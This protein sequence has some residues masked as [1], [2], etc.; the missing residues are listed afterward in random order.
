MQTFINGYDI[1]HCTLCPRKCGMD[2]TRAAGFCGG[3]SEIRA[4]RRALHHWEEPCTSG[5]GGSG[6]IFFSG[7]SLRCCFC[8][9]A[10]IRTGHFGA[11]L[12]I[13]QLGACMLD[14]QQQG[15][16][17]INF[18]TGSH[19]TPWIVSAVQ[20]IRDKLHIPIV[21][22][23]SGYEDAE[24]LAM[25]DGV[26]DIYLPDFKYFC[27]ETAE[28]YAQARNYPEVAAYALT[29][30]LRQV[31]TPVFDENG[32][33]QRGMIVRH[34]VLPGH[35]HESMALLKA[36]SQLLPKEDFLLS[37]MGQYT[38]PSEA[39]PYKNL[40]RRLTTMEYQSVLHCAQELDFQGFSQELSS[41]QASY[42]PPL[43][44]EGIPH[45][46]KITE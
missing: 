8:Q 22:N 21:W 15:A 4:A 44:L 18:V 30:M 17:N 35:R 36:L 27:A 37:L 42:I 26:V 45:D 19:Y 33:L 3:G 10:V 13:D 28:K 25:L 34:L 43:N 7:C 38:P 20:K 24:T 12:T 11:P 41:A 40:N 6:T 9:N 46:T 23:S 31:G 32:I 2:R 1:T 39:C 29:E 5:T 14:L 16:H